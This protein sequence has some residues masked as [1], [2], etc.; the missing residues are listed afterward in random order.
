M[1]TLQSIH[2]YTQ[3]DLFGV[4]FQLIKHFKF[5][6]S[7]HILHHGTEEKCKRYVHI[8]I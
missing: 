7:K 2:K 5:T 3:S 1:D 6:K 8:N 4:S